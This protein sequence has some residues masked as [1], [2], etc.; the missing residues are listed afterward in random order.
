MIRSKADVASS[1]LCA[2]RPFQSIST[3]GAH[4]A[5]G[6]RRYNGADSLD[7][8]EPPCLLAR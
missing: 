3:P 5:L 1:P 2:A 4:I 8:K 6:P 7:V